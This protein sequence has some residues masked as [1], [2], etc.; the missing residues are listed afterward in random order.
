M[1]FVGD[2]KAPLAIGKKGELFDLID[3]E[4]LEIWSLYRFKRQGMY[5]VD[6][7]TAPWKLSYGCLILGEL[8]G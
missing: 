3:E 2:P 1:Y 5:K 8:D 4:F 7:L 6:M